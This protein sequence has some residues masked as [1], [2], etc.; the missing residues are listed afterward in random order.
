[1]LVGVLFNPR[2]F[3]IGAHYSIYNRRVCINVL[4]MLTIWITFKGGVIPRTCDK[5]EPEITINGTRLTDVQV[6]IVR[7][8]L[9]LF[10][11]H[12]AEHGMGYDDQGQPQ[13]DR[14]LQRIAKIKALWR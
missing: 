11:R 6:M 4:P 10:S 3:W 1:M 13:A 8:G 5:N 2:A 12:I 9:E 14:Y 7:T